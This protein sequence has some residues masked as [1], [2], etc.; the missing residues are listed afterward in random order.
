MIPSLLSV[1]AYVP[2]WIPTSS[3]LWCSSFRNLPACTLLSYSGIGPPP[4]IGSASTTVAIDR[5]RLKHDVDR[6]AP[7]TVRACCVCRQY[8]PVLK[9]CGVALVRSALANL[10][11][12]ADGR[13]NRG[14]RAVALHLSAPRIL[15]ECMSQ[16]SRR[17]RLRSFVG[18]FTEISLQHEAVNHT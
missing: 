10:P 11:P 12:S 16:E 5:D 2:G 18:E 1:L 14:W 4:C 9:P 6:L 8:K 13:N 17:L 7:W 3:P 15:M